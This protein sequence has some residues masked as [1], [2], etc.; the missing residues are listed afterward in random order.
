M[1]AKTMYMDI[2]ILKNFPKK[3]NVGAYKEKNT[4]F[5]NQKEHQYR[6]F[7]KKVNTF[8]GVILLVATK[9]RMQ[10]FVTYKEHQYSLCHH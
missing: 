4:F 7:I 2:S 5:A 9:G 10:F 6:I 8:W 3:N 1:P